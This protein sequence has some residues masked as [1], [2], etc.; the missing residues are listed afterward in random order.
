[1]IG[2]ALGLCGGSVF[3]ALQGKK[4][5]TKNEEKEKDEK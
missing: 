3:G 1:M 4:K 2:A 5:E